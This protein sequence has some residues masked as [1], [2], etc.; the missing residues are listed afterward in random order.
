MEKTFTKND[1]L[2][3]IYG[4]SSA[5]DSEMIQ[6]ELLVNEDFN[7]EFENLLEISAML[8]PNS[9]KPNPQISARL[10]NFSKSI[11]T[12]QSRYSKCKL[13]WLLN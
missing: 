4:E 11:E 7:Q 3:F 1:L 5:Q 9:E 10:M 6:Y 8:K 13:L 2:Q 12:A